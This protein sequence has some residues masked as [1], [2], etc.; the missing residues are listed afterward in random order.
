MPDHQTP[1][2]PAPRSTQA[3]VLLSEAP[4]PGSNADIPPQPQRWGQLYGSARSLALAELVQSARQPTLIIAASMPELLQ[5]EA[6]MQFFLHDPGRLHSFVEW[7]T[8]PFDLVSPHQDIIAQRIRTLHHLSSDFRDVLLISAS[9]LMQRVAP[10]AFLDQHALRF[11]TGQTLPIDDFRKRLIEA[12]Y[13]HVSQVEEHGEFAIRGSILDLFPMTSHSAYRIEYFD[14]EIDSIRTF[15]TDTQISTGKMDTVEL[16]PAHEFPLNEDGIRQFRR[17]FRTQFDVDVR[18]NSVYRGVSDGH[19]PAGIEYYMPL[20]FDEMSTLF[21]YLPEQLQVLITEDAEQAFDTFHANTEERYEQ[22]RH[23][24]ERPIL[25]VDSLYLSPEETLERLNAHHPIRLQRHEIERAR[26]GEK[27]HN[28]NTS[29]PGH[30]PVNPRAEDPLSLFR[31]FLDDFSGKVLLVAESTG[32][33]ETLLDQLI[34]N[35]LSVTVVDGWQEFLTADIALAL[36]DGSVDA[37]LLL[38]GQGIAVVAESQLG[39]GRV[40]RRERRAPARDASAIIANLT[41]LSIDDPVVHIDHGVG[42]YQGLTLLDI[43]GTQTEFLTLTYAGSDK[44]YVP[45]SSLHLISRYAGASADTAPLHRLGSDTWQKVKRRAAEKAHDVAAELLEIHARRVARQGYA[46]PEASSN[47]DIFAAAFPFEET[48]DQQQ[49]IDDV[50]TDLRASTPTDRVVC[51][52]VGFGKTEVAMRAAFVAADAGKQVAVL[53]PT[54]L[55]AQQ[56][57]QNFRDR[58]ADWPVNI[59]ALSRFNTAAEQRDVLKRL[60]AGGVDIII[61]THKLI[62]KDV[63]YKNLGLVIIDEEHRF[64]VRHKEH[65]KALRAEVD[66]LTLTATP[67]PRTLNMGLAGLRSL[68]IIATA[69]AHRHAIKTFVIEWSDVQIREAIERELARGGQVYFLHNEVASIERITRTVEEIAPGAEVRYAHGQMREAELEAVM[70]DFYHQRFNVLISTTIIESG[71]DIPSAN[72][73]IMNRAD[74]LGL[75]QLHQL[76]GRVGRSHH[77]AYAYLIA[78]PRNLLTADADK[79]LTAIESLE[80]L[81]VGFSLATQDL[82]IRG[83]GELL[84][85][86]QSGQIQEIGFTLYSELLERAVN[87]LKSGRIPDHDQPLAQ[88]SNV[89]LGLPALLPADYVPDVHMRLVL[90]KRIAHAADDEALREL[91]VELI[92]RFGLLPEATDN[93]FATVALKLRCEELG[94]HRLEINAAGGRIEFDI[95]PKIEPANLIILVQ[96]RSDEF[97]FDGSTRLRIIREFDTLQDRVDYLEDLLQTLKGTN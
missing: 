45:V 18:S 68:S 80:E 32:R 27:K 84:G 72:T 44:L 52:D 31:H 29:A 58:F 74:K 59:E 62:Q 82:E 39:S 22:R 94:I 69:P 50:L 5:I 87:A 92:D 1:L 89:D 78:P 23:D 17:A 54:T 83:A 26:R 63:K 10:R 93:L 37:G 64:G 15:D 21:D 38:P 97:R 35:R 51:G 14:D 2:S 40:R 81:G 42:R 13:R 11:R 67:I 85:E 71:I 6:E 12:G 65:M 48:P 55:L 53:V 24:I 96:T 41:D 47:Y 91:K 8:L 34:G 49:A 33:R 57:Y 9:A 56:H 19:A 16:L 79:R 70:Y 30:W 90:Y 76:R 77:R 28:F 3:Q 4:L 88:A 25:P 95:Q 36:T 61:G 66:I 46:F 60:A 43:N 20:F 73:I 86:D 75:A 7:E